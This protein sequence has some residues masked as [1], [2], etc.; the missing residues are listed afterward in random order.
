VLQKLS[1][2]TII[3]TE[4]LVSRQMVP[5]VQIRAS[6]E[7]NLAPNGFAVAYRWRA[8]SPKLWPPLELCTNDLVRDADLLLVHAFR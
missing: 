2:S 3:A 8:I 4:C 7:L 6:F 5:E 1:H